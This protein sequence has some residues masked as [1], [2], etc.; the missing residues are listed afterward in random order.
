[1]KNNIYCIEK[2]KKNCVKDAIKNVEDQVNKT[3]TKDT[4]KR[5]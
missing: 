1:M 4:Y 3:E 2:R 5:H